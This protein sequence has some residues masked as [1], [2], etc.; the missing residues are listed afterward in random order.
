MAKNSVVYL[1][2]VTGD[3]P[4]QTIADRHIGKYD[5]PAMGVEDIRNLLARVM[6]GQEDGKVHVFQDKCDGTAA[7]GTIACTQANATAGET[8]TIAGVVFTIASSPSTDPA[9]GEL[10][11]GASDTAFGDNLAAAINAH[12][13][14]KGL[15]TAANAAGTVTITADDKG[16]F[17]NLIRMS[18][19]GDAFVVT[20]P[21]NG[22][23]GTVQ[24]FMRTFRRGL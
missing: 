22:A 12:P 3:T 18:E 13:A 24:S 19:T 8:V 20:N 11:A 10:A 1:A 17:G 2:I 21:T 14:L 5:N 15:L 6:S 9:R 23:I 4:A 7:T 16:L